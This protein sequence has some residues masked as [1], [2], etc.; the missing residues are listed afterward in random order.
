MKWN[1]TSPSQS[2]AKHNGGVGVYVSQS[3][4]QLRERLYVKFD[5]AHLSLQ[6]LNVN[7]DSATHWTDN[8]ASDGA[9]V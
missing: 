6:R 2:Q 9:D 8:S 3:Y 7:D 4:I 5:L 1:L